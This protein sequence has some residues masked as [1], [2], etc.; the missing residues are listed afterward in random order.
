MKT[1][2]TKDNVRKL[3]SDARAENERFFKRL[4]KKV[5]A[6]LDEIVHELHDAIAGNRNKSRK[7]P[8]WTW[9]KVNIS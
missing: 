9:I 2:P 1:A 6:N 8:T 5:P 7:I 4:K 3:A